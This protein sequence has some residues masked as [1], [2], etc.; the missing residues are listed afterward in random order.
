MR[1]AARA[2]GGAE[3]DRALE[4]MKEA[5]RLLE[6]ARSSDRGDESERRKGSSEGDR[7]KPDKDHPNGTDDRSGDIPI[8]KAEDYKGPEAFRRRAL[9]GLGGAAD[10]RLKD[11]VKRYA[12]G[13]FE[14][15]SETALVSSRSALPFPGR[16]APTTTAGRARRG[17]PR[18]RSTFARRTSC[19]TAPTRAT[20]RSRS[21]A[22][23]WPSTT[24]I[25]TAPVALLSRADLAA[26]RRR[27]R[28]PRASPP[29]ARGPPRARSPRSTP[30]AA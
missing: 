19:S 16:S 10:P 9:E 17:K 14:M 7:G 11:A 6:M 15:K 18:S 23:G 4:R 21:S 13:F 22:P 26:L 25:T 27:R 12:E 5:Q 2:L 29:V 20:R 24:A 28:A 3:G 30:R 8:P 1:E